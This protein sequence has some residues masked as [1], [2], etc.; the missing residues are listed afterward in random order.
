MN[1]VD[2]ILRIPA[3]QE[4]IYCLFNFA[5]NSLL[6]ILVNKHT[7]IRQT[8]DQNWNISNSLCL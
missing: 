6:N 8:T 7:V 5:F 3:Q 2:D 1:I 4:D